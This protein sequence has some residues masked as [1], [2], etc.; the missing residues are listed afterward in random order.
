M[1]LSDYVHLIKPRIIPLLILV[2][3]SSAIIA[4]RAVPSLT[5]ILGL[6]VAGTLTSGGALAINSYLEADIDAMM[7]RTRNRPLPSGRIVPRRRALLVG[8]T[9]LLAGI[10]VSALTLPILGTLFIV[11]G[12]V[13]YVP[14]YTLWLKP[15][16]TWN[17]VLGGFA[18]SCASLAGW[19]SI[20][21]SQPL[22]ASTLAALVFV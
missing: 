10:V 21:T 6:L 22:I 19:Y 2:A 15:R 14:I 16:T 1:S 8:L 11:L 5:V 17:I 20:T 13:V 12:A 3:L 4:A 7:A 9:L 18:G